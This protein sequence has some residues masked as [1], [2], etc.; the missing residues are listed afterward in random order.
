MKVSRRPA[1][2]CSGRR[3]SRQQPERLDLAR[4]ALVKAAERVAEPAQRAGRA[5]AQDHPRLPGLTQELV[6]PVRPPGA[7]QR[8]E[9]ATADV[10]QILREQ[11]RAR[12][13]TPVSRRNSEMCEGSQRSAENAL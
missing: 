4:R 7:E 3:S 8:H 2:R 1:P 12:I 6:D 13:P 9:A 10:D 5:P 11:V